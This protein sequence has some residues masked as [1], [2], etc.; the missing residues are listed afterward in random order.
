MK[1]TPQGIPL[2]AI[3]TVEEIHSKKFRVTTMLYAGDKIVVTGEVIAV[4]MPDKFIRD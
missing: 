2:K 4:V 1:P 3:G